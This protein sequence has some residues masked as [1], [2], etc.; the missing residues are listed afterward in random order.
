MEP[1]LQVTQTAWFDLEYQ[2][3]STAWPNI[4]YLQSCGS[5]E[6]LP[7]EVNAT[8]I[9]DILNILTFPNETLIVSMH[10][11]FASYS[12]INAMIAVLLVELQP[13]RWQPFLTPAQ[14]DAQIQAHRQYY[15]HG[16]ESCQAYELDNSTMLLLNPTLKNEVAN[17]ISTLAKKMI[18]GA[19]LVPPKEDT[20]TI[21]CERATVYVF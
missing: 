4:L 3:Q 8:N 17:L 20:Y 5:I 9:L 16:L 2:R 6:Y 1:Q 19:G 18:M 12:I 7:T 15:N 10:C 14:F 21:I 11:N 13:N